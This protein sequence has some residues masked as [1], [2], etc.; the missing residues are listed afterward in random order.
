MK[1]LKK[2]QQLK[3]YSKTLFS[4]SNKISDTPKGMIDYILSH[5][6]LLSNDRLLAELAE[7]THSSSHTTEIANILTSKLEK[8]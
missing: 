5:S 6:D 4:K 7:A 8:F 3:D 1:L 2:V